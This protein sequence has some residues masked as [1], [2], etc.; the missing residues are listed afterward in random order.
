MSNFSPCPR[1]ETGKAEWSLQDKGGKGLF[2]KE[3]E[4]AL[5][6]G[7]ADLAVHSAKDLPTDNPPGLK[8]SA[9]PCS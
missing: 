2:T 4:N 7:R 9:F 6:E 3:L 5:L 8:L 1:R